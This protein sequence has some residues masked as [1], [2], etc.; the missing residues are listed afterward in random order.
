MKTPV[1]SL[2]LTALIHFLKLGWII[3]YISHFLK[4]SVERLLI[5]Y[6]LYRIIVGSTLLTII[7]CSHENNYSLLQKIHWLGCSFYERNYTQFRMVPFYPMYYYQRWG[8]KGC[9]PT[10]TWVVSHVY[11]KYRGK[12]RTSKN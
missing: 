10:F 3:I 11:P 2:W 7:V 4:I 6:Q 12:K 9:C 8:Q 1:S 5:N